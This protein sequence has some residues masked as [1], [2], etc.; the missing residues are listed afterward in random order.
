ME[1]KINFVLLFISIFI[2]GCK[3]EIDNKIDDVAEN[4]D[5]IYFASQKSFN[6]NQS[7]FL[8]DGASKDQNFVFFK[9]SG[10]GNVIWID[11][12]LYEIK[13]QKTFFSIIR[14]PTQGYFILYYNGDSLFNQIID[15]RNC[16]RIDTNISD[17]GLTELI[18][19]DSMYS[20]GYL[21]YVTFNCKLSDN[22][23]LVKNES[24]FTKVSIKPK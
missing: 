20:F 13:G 14:E 6:Q 22:C 11:S 8:V 1:N 10:K 17:G 4:Y 7:A 3:N 21:N 9:S 23:L 15:R 16:P 5:S 19:R 12:V 2:F 18:I 24:S